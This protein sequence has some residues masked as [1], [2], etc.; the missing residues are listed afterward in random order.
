VRRAVTRVVSRERTTAL[1]HAPATADDVR[2]F[3]EDGLPLLRAEIAWLHE[4]VRE[5]GGELVVAFVPFREGVYGDAG[6]WPD[7]LRWK[8]REIAEAASDV[9]RRRGLRFRDVTAALAPR[10]ASAPSAL[11]HQGAETH[12]TPAGYRAIAEEVAGLLAESAPR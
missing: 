1:G 4:R 10:A 3:R 6:W 9:C 11:Y 2:R 7:E 8:S 12:P 5:D